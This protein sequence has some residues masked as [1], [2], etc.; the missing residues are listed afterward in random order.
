MVGLEVYEDQKKFSTE[1]FR[2]KGFDL[3]TMTEKERI[4]WTK[5]ILLS[6]HKEISEV[7][8]TLDWKLHRK[9]QTGRLIKGNLIEEIVDA[10]KYLW[11]IPVLWGMTWEDLEEAYW[12]KSFVV[13]KRFETEHS[14]LKP[15]VLI[16]DLDGV[17]GEYPKGFLDWV[18]KTHSSVE[19]DSKES[20][21]VLWEELKDEFRS[22]GGE[23]TISPIKGSREALHGFRN[24]DWSIVVLTHRPVTR[25]KSLEYDTLK[26]LDTNDLLYDKIFWAELEKSFY[27]LEGVVGGTVFVDD[28]LDIC[29]TMKSLVSRVYYVGHKKETGI[30]TVSS[31]EEVAKSEQVL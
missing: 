7:L 12:R 8:D 11:N 23:L 29:K 1:L 2:K 22:T 9:K 16:T 10:Q 15:K 5:E 27:L 6:L 28:S 30:I 21:P 31:L 24:R 18:K 14:I 25:Y 13:Q 17:L 4:D 19:L 20:N 26:W 3:E